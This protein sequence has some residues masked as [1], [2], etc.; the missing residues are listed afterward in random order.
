MDLWEKLG[1]TICA[2]GVLVIIVAISLVLFMPHTFEGY[3]LAGGKI[4]ASHKW[5]P[6]E[7]AYYYYDTPEMWQSIIKNNLHLEPK[8]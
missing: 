7:K 3:Y 8:K 2:V 1:W 6:D 4:W 5:A